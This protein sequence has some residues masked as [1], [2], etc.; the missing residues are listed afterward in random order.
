MQKLKVAAK[1]LNYKI[2]LHKSGASYE[3]HD[4]STTHDYD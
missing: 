2:Q 1:Q 3:F 4:S